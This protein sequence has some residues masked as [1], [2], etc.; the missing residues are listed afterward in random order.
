MPQIAGFREIL[1]N[2]SKVE[3]AKVAATPITEPRKRLEDGELVRDPTR[4]V[5]RYHQAFAA[6]PRTLVRKSWFAAI[7]L[8][9]W[10]EGTVRPHEAT[11]PKARD[12]ACLLYTSDAADEE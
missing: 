10:S 8:S 11:D 2:T 9:P 1:W 3:L 6:G 7:A 4:A 5:Y 12:K